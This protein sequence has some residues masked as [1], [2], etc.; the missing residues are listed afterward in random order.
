MWCLEGD[1]MRCSERTKP[2]APVALCRRMLASRHSLKLSVNVRTISGLL[3]K[4]RTKGKDDM[5]L[6]RTAAPARRGSAQ[7]LGRSRG[8]VRTHARGWQRVCSKD[9][10]GQKG[11]LVL[12]FSLLSTALEQSF[13]KRDHTITSLKT[14]GSCCS[15]RP[16]SQQRN[17]RRR[18]GAS[19]CC[20][21]RQVL[22]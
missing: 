1:A 12:R 9:E 5:Q 8:A 17:Q 19:A 20:H 14:K 2:E 16:C 3:R 4:P 18:K 21:R 7:R 22:R 11:R 6:V 13:E 10:L 15:L